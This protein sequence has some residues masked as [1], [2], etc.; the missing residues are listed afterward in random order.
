MACCAF[1]VTVRDPVPAAK[2]EFPS[3]VAVTVQVPGLTAV[4]RPA[5]NVQ[6]P[7]GELETVIVTSPPD[8]TTTDKGWL[9]PISIANSAFGVKTGVFARV[10]VPT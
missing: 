8:G 1:T 7:L 10:P 2:V 5:P 4:I 3:A 9:E 6:A